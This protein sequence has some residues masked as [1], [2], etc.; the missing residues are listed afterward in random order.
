MSLFPLT[1]KNQFNIFDLLFSHQCSLCKEKSKT[2]FDLCE[3]CFEE[4]PY[5]RNFCRRCGAFLADH[6]QHNVCG[7]CINKNLPYQ[8]TF[9][10]FQYCSPIDQMLLDLKFR[11]KLFFVKS[12]SKLLAAGIAKFYVENE[13]PELIIPIPLYVNRLRERGFNQALELVRATSLQL[14]I[15]LDFTSCLRKKNTAA[16]TS[17][18]ESE[19]KR[20]LHQAFSL[21]KPILAK[22][23]AVFD[24]VITTGSTMREFC[25]MLAKNG[26]EKIDVWCLAKTNTSFF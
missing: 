4:L 13:L 11:Q 9:V 20:N 23:I 15:P 24:D 17:L 2:G 10:L 19:R 7:N 8:K 6:V 1:F 5:V 14:K 16:Q 21:T 25:K 22:H 18:K 26:I 3:Q 12:L